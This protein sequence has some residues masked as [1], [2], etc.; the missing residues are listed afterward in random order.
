MKRKVFFLGLIFI[1]L[2]GFTL[3]SNNNLIIA[4]DGPKFEY[5]KEANTFDL[6]TLY[7]DELEEV[8]LEI[9]F[10]NKGDKPLV[11]THVR[12]CC[13]TRVKDWTKEPIQPGEKGTIE[14]HFRLAPRPHNISRTV[15]AMS[16]DADGQ[17]VLRIRGRVAERDETLDQQF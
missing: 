3:M 11:V 4:S 12:A 17:K 8:N 15:V 7:I 10:E 14:V 1:G 5:T 2:F 13:G 6:G 9:E 16:N